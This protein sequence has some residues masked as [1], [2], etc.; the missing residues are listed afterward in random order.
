MDKNKLIKVLEEVEKDCKEDASKLDGQPFNGKTVATQL[1]YQL[2]AISAIAQVLK[3]F[4]QNE[5]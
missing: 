1:G 2:A 4:I 3:E 5:K